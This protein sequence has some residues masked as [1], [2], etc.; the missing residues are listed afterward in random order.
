MSSAPSFEGYILAMDGTFL[1][2]SLAR[3]TNNTS[4]PDESL[5]ESGDDV[6][7]TEV[8]YVDSNNARKGRPSELLHASA[9]KINEGAKAYGSRH[10]S[11]DIARAR[12]EK[13]SDNSLRK[14]DTH[15][16]SFVSASICLISDS[17]E[18]SSIYLLWP[19]PSFVGA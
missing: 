7:K 2:S 12:D 19:E 16:I 4:V 3:S 6:S 8:S 5:P 18:P 9:L 13:S 10:G 17:I 1:G 15:K 11:D 14:T